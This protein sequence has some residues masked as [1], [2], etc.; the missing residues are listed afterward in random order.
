M[1]QIKRLV[2]SLSMSQRWTVL[3]TAVVLVLGVYGL[4]QWRR[5]ANFKTLYTS[6]APEDAGLVVQKLKE[7]GLEYKLSENGT[8]IS[9]P[10]E[11]IA[12][13]RLE[14]ASAGIPKTGRIGFELFDKTNF[15]ITEF[16]EHV[17]YR[18]ALEGE[19]ERSIISI[20][21]VEQARVHLTFPKESVFVD[22]REPAKASVLIRLRTGAH[23]SDSSVPAITHLVASAVEGLAP[24]YVSVLDDHGH[25]LNRPKRPGAGSNDELSQA[26]LEYQQQVEKELGAK[27]SATLDPLVGTGRFRTAVLADCDMS[28][29][30]QTEENYDPTKSVMVTSQITED[31]TGMGAVTGG[32]PG[33]ASNLPSPP[34]QKSGSN[35]ANRRTENISYQSS[36]LVRRTVLPQGTVKRLSVSVLIDQDVRW[37]GNAPHQKRVIVPPD[38]GRMKSIHDLVAAAIGFKADRGDQ[39]IVESLPFEATLTEEPPLPPAAPVKAPTPIDQVKADPIRYVMLGGIGVAVLVLL[40]VVTSALRRARPVQVTAVPRHLPEAEPP[41]LDSYTPAHS[42]GETSPAE[43]RQLG[44]ARPAFEVLVAQLRESAGK[45]SEVYAGVLRGWLREERS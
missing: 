4:M 8:T 23:L 34:P 32:V 14:M 19:L 13:L 37:E 7:K 33:T 6:L 26:A 45:D 11:K 27:L 12:E 43:P 15:G 24:E 17:N 2:D 28:S 16:A 9:A 30:E 36:R 35:T 3:I 21:E 31:R 18:R 41:V 1:D 20:A 5:E 42:I 38:A 29:A 39:L 44:P 10:S 25:L 22:S 40:F